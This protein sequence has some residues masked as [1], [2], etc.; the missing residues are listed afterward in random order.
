MASLSELLN[1]TAMDDHD[2]AA[3][4]PMGE[5]EAD[6]RSDA[7]HA[8]LGGAAEHLLLKEVGTSLRIQNLDQWFTS[9]YT[10]FKEKGFACIVTSRVVNLLTLG[11]TI[12]FSG[13]LLLYVD[14]K[15]LRTACAENGSQCDILRDSTYS[16]PLRHRGALTNLVVVMYLILFS[17]YWTWS[18]ARLV[19]DLRPLLEMRAF[20]NHKLQ[21]SDRDIQTISWP[22]VVARV[23]HLQATTRVSIVRD[24]NEH[25]IIARILRKEN[26]MMGMLNR[27]VLGLTLDVPG[28]KWLPK[29]LRG[30]VWLTKCVEWNIEWAV[31]NGMFDDDFSIRASFYDVAALRQRMRYLAVANLLLSPFLAIFM[32]MYFLMHNAEK[33]YHQPSSVGHRQWSTHAW[34][35]LREFNELSHFTEHRLA[36]AHR[37]ATRYVAQFPSPTVSMVAKFVSYIVGAFAAVAIACALIDD[38]LLHAEVFGRDLLWFTAVM[39]TV[40]AASRGMIGEENRVFEPNK[41]MGEVVGHTH[42]LPRHWRNLAHKQEVQAEFEEMFQFKAALF[43]QEMLSIFAMPFIL[44]YPMCANAPDIIQ[45]VRQFTVHRPGVG[46]ICSL[47][48]FDFRRHGNSKYGAPVRARK[49]ARSKQ[50]KMEKSFLSF[51]AQYPT[52]EPDASGREMLSALADFRSSVHNGSAAAAAYEGCVR[53]SSGMH[54][55]SAAL[56][57]VPPGSASMFFDHSTMMGGGVA[58]ASAAAGLTTAGA[59]RMRSARFRAVSGGGAGSSTYVQP[60]NHGLFGHG[61]AHGGSISHLG[62]DDDLDATTNERAETESQVLLQQYYECHQTGAA[63]VATAPH[64]PGA[65]VNES[66]KPEDPGQYEGGAKGQNTGERGSGVGP[67]TEVFETEMVNSTPLGAS[68]LTPEAQAPRPNLAMPSAASPAGAMASPFAAAA[69]ITAPTLLTSQATS[70]MDAATIQSTALAPAGSHMLTPVSANECDPL[71]SL[72]VSQARETDA[73]AEVDDGLVDPDG[74]FENPPDLWNLEAPERARQQRREPGDVF[75]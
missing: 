58:A 14:W 17:T 23:V 22:E 43:L 57:F 11:F 29:W 10:Y 59:L 55:T 24:L 31:F 21:L 36:A 4:P 61:G 16:S 40:L 42:F 28:L 5:E 26:Y 65:S 44:W 19:M 51:H 3:L 20:C 67:G 27:G 41:V 33:F 25:D 52:W 66:P 71:G 69:T 8:H 2:Y 48:A 18:L 73:G 32:V 54:S 30:H 6:L 56:R 15:Y 50:G 37:P 1:P 12:F 13:F 62:V 63:P 46:H 34:W 38:R 39:G 70:S 64:G 35:R 49:E 74:T 9:L 75:E 68:A 47:S 60:T 53:A 45:F 72:L 7:S